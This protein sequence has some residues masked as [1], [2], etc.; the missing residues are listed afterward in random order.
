MQV[1]TKP[2]A[3][4]QTLI[5]SLGLDRGERDALALLESFA[6]CLLFCDDAAARLAAESL[7]FSVHGT[8]GILVRSIRVGSRTRQD[9]IDVLRQIPHKSSLHISGQLLETVIAEVEKAP[10]EYR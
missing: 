9:A 6:G 3:I 4:L 8:I 10:P 2:S 5:V 7:G 1:R